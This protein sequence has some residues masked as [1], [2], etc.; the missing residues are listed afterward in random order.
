MGNNDTFVRGMLQLDWEMPEVRS[1]LLKMRRREN[2][3]GRVVFVDLQT[4]EAVVST[5]PLGV[6]WWIGRVVNYS[7]DFIAVSSLTFIT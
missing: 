6:D 1:L 5:P 4:G 7:S 3:L 2:V